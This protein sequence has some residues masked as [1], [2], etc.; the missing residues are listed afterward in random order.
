MRKMTRTISG[1]TPVAVVAR[2]GPCPGECIYCPNFPQTPRSYTP[3]S[4]AVIRA[5]GYGFD[6]RDQVRARLAHLEAMGHPTDK[7]E[8]ILLGGTFLAYPPDY[9]ERFIQE[10]Y[11]AVNGQPSGSLEEALATNEQA[12]RRVVGVC[13]ETRPDWCGER[14]IDRLLRWGVTRVELG[15]QTLDD[16]I[17]RLVRRG[18]TV[19]EVIEATRLLRQHGLKVHYHWMPGLPG[20]TPEKDLEMTRRLFADPALRP[21]GLKLYPT[22]VVAGTLLEEWY[23]QGKYQPYSQGVLVELLAEIKALVPPYCRVSRLMR[24]IPP[25]FIVA[26]PRDSRLRELV[27][28]RMAAR[29]LPCQCIRCREY[30][31]RARQG[32]AP[33]EPA[34]RKRE[35]QASGGEEIFLSFDDSQDS[36][37]GLLRLRLERGRALVRELHVYGP[38]VPLG[39]KSP[40]APQHR[41][42]GRA[43]LQEAEGLAAQAGAQELRILS[44]VGAREYYRGLGYRL[45]G[46]YMVRALPALASGRLPGRAS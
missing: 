25:E 33:G 17:Y 38:E 3:R 44:G 30:G 46:P 39:E 36:L 5:L 18:H 45:Q 1:V 2:P 42:L 35:Y 24:D 41:G 19:A 21:D 11:D 32:W 29:G 28:A 8:L 34:L 15:V 27:Q 43:L 40:T 7:V 31:H 14:E 4:P 16:A 9:Q 22:L 23:R 20:S 37:F 26:G 13:L 12:A 6:A 10:C